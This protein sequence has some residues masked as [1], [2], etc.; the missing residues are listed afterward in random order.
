M[1]HYTRNLAPEWAEYNVRVNSIAPAF[2]KA[3][4]LTAYPEM[5]EAMRL[6]N[7]MRRFAT[8]REVNAAIQFLASDAASFIPGQV[9]SVDGGSAL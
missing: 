9:I 7:P 6:R 4:N 1:A 5:Y 2:I 3:Y 8:E